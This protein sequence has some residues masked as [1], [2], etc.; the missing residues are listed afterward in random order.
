MRS[1][2]RFIR[3][4]PLA[5]KITVSSG[6]ALLI[7]AGVEALQYRESR[8]RIEADEAITETSEVLKQLE[9]VIS[10]VKD[11][12]STGRGYVDTGD[13]KLIRP[14]DLS[15]TGIRGHLQ[16]LRR[17]AGPVQPRNLDK[18]EPL[19]NLKLAHIQ[20]LIQLRQ[21]KGI[22]AA[23]TLMRQGEGIRL[24]TQI[25]ALGAMM[26]VQ[27]NGWLR[28]REAASRRAA[29]DLNWAI[30]IG[31]ILALGIVMMAGAVIHRDVAENERAEAA[32]R[33]SEEH[34]RSL[35]ENML[36]GYAFCKMHF[37]QEKP[38]DF[39]YISV[40]AAFE[41]LT[42]LKGV[43]GK[44]VS[45]VI[46][47]LRESDPELFKIYGRVA[48]TGKPEHFETYVDALADWYEISVY[49]PRQEHFVAIFD[50]ITERKQAED[51]IRRSEAQ[52]RS[53]VA[54][55]PDVVWTMGSD[56]KFVYISPRIESISGYSQEEI[57]QMGASLFLES[58][59]PDDIQKVKEGLGALLQKG[60]PYDV[61]CRVRRK[62]GEWMWIHDRAVATYEKNGMLYAD[63][64]L[65]DITERKQAEAESRR[66][67]SLVNS[68]N[69]AIFSATPDG[70]IVTWN[71]A[72]EHMYG[73]TGEEIKGKHFA[74]FVP[75]DQRGVL[76]SIQEKLSRGEVIRQ[77]RHENR[78]KDGSRFQV[79]LSL[80]PIKD[81]VGAVTGLSAIVRD[82]TEQKLAEDALKESEERFRSLVENAT[83][84]IYR[85]TPQGRIV[86]AN[87]A[88]VQMLGFDEFKELA[89]R[90]LE[91]QGFHSD[92]PRSDF[93]EQL[94]RDGVVKGREAVW[95]RKDGSTIF[96]YESAKAIRGPDGRVIYYDGI[97]ED[98]SDRKRAEKALVE[99]RNLLVTLMDNLPDVIYFKDRASHFTRI[100]RA[101]AQEFAVDDPTLA[102]GKTDFDFFADEHAR[103]AFADERE[104][105]RTGEPVLDKEEKEVWPDGR[106]TWVATTKMPL[107]DAKGNIIGTFG[108]SRDITARKQAEEALRQSEEKYRTIVLN[109][110]DVV[111]TIDSQG[112]IIFV[113]PNI[114][115][116]GGWTTEEVY[117]GGIE[118]FL[119]TVHPDD[120]PL[121][122]E[123]FRSG[124]Q[125]QRP[126][127]VE[128]RGRCKDGRWIW[129]RARAMQAIEKEGVKYLQ[130]LLTDVT[131]R[132][133]A[134]EEHTRLVT[135]IEQSS[136][137][138]VITNPLGTIEYVNSAF[139]RI[140]GY[141]RAEA[142]GQNPRIL[143]SGVHPLEFYEQLW[144]TILK[145]ETWRGELT[146]RRKDG[147]TYLDQMSITPVRDARGEVAHFI[148]TKQ[149]VTERRT[150]EQQVRQA[151]K[152][153]A[154]G[155]VAGGVAHDFNNLLTIINGYS[156]ILL[157]RPELDNLTVSYLKVVKDAGERAAALTRQLLAFSRLQVLAP[158]VFDLNSAVSNLEKMLRRLIGEDIKLRTDL[159]P[160][161]GRVKADPGQ[162][163]QVIMNLAV[164]ARDA[165]L[166]GG[167]ISLE[168]RNVEL[169][170]EYARTHATVKPGLHVMLAV[171]DTGVGMTA[172]TQAHIFEPFFT[173]KE[174]GKGTGLGLSTVYGIVKQS[175]GSI[176]VYSEL[177]QGT[178]FKIYLPRVDANA[179]SGDSVMAETDAASGAETILLVEDDE[180]VRSLV[181]LALAGGGYRVLETQNPQG[182]LEVCVN[183][184]G[185]IHLLLTDVVMPEMS[186]PVV[187]S[188]VAALRPGI[189]VLYMSGYTD[190]AVVHHGVLSQEMPFIQKPFSPL[191]LRKKIREVLGENS[192]LAG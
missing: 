131:E 11:A 85:T 51:A 83:V 93:R 63:G 96:A 97:V 113:S 90:N 126:P 190:D 108:V 171:G 172:E 66:L 157:E 7:L 104:I 147:S 101:L 91:E 158:Q 14:L 114:E 170:E 2:L 35:F 20:E 151:T 87:P 24:M 31:A 1:L 67:A 111:W 43:V 103:E 148:A 175:G 13:E 146:N 174:V 188:K 139:T 105:M 163:E 112:R 79:S 81:A 121:M 167:T 9:G 19:V 88:L 47:G 154:V 128:Y 185:P 106:T 41:T 133:Q 130:G 134:E 21:D 184:K 45:E 55:I 80:S 17:L 132:H 30:G 18:L 28:E 123:V 166:Q 177:G 182:A 53:L 54:N 191:A 42:G 176:W 48:L 189:R 86:M 159:D 183:Y 15:T 109:I 36:N 137:G 120:L 39:T 186:G 149:D 32:L 4:S 95:H 153:E 8:I 73:Y 115:K 144:T 84:G 135:A 138:V 173:T 70:L 52:Y 68:S 23:T 116:L 119:S 168:T 124:F 161:L 50:V 34:F 76:A 192:E 98:I 56:M 49:S 6:L 181:R 27:E 10:D 179:E 57:Y 82:I 150:L 22:S 72:A 187:A 127:D 60:H 58:I 110:P 122:Q 62:S 162:I 25:R 29:R 16:G 156:E 61:E 129:V 102:I 164:N 64:L 46:P 69:D 117:A 33:K 59:H 78:R 26:E 100:N 169:D 160:A 44:R 118:F 165:M 141:T 145:G 143:K 89:E 140:T 94:E 37:D 136:E 180:G 92:S 125:E 74:V 71:P 107:R 3:H 77:F 38:V 5:M 65:S 155:R 12:E 178:V 152:M 75:E 40:N 99:E 142:I